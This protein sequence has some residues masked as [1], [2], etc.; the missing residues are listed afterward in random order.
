[1]F[2]TQRDKAI[3]SPAVLCLMELTYDIEFQ[4][5]F[6]ESRCNDSRFSI[7]GLSLCLIC[8]LSLIVVLFVDCPKLMCIEDGQEG[9]LPYKPPSMY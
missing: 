2:F 1:M 9:V 5:R 3:E 6:P 4:N 7:S 8:R